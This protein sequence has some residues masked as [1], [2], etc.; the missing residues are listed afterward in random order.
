[1]PDTLRFSN[2]LEVVNQF[3]EVVNC[4]SCRKSCSELQFVGASC[5]HAFCWECIVSFKSAD[6][7]RKKLPLCPE[8][9]L[10]LDLNKISGATT[11]NNCYGYLE[12]LSDLLLQFDKAAGQ[13]DHNL[14]ATQ[15]ILTN[16]ENTGFKARTIEEF[17]CTQ[18]VEFLE[19]EGFDEGEKAC[20][21]PEYDLFGELHLNNIP[22]R[23]IKEPQ[24]STDK[25]SNAQDSREK[26]RRR[27]DSS[28]E[29]FLSKLPCGADLLFMSQVP[30]KNLAD[31][32]TPFVPRRSSIPAPRKYEHLG[33]AVDGLSLI[34]EDEEAL[35]ADD[36]AFSKKVTLTRKMSSASSEAP[37]IS[38]EGSKR[39]SM[40]PARSKRKSVAGHR[41]ENVIMSAI[42]NN[43]PD[44]LQKAIEA[45]EDV[46]ES[47]SRGFM[48]LYVATENNNFEAARM[49]I[50]AGAIINAACGPRC[51]TALH[52]A[53][54]CQNFDMIELLLQ[55]GASLKVKDIGGDTTFE[56][57]QYCRATRDLCQKYIEKPRPLQPIIMPPRAKTFQV[58]LIDPSLATRWAKKKL[59][60]NV[61]IVTRDDFSYTHLALEVDDAGL[62]VLDGTNM[63]TVLKAMMKSINIVSLSWLE[64]CLEGQVQAVERPYEISQIRVLSGGPIV[65]KS[66]EKWRKCIER[67][68]AKLFSGCKFYFLRPR[69]EMLE[70]TQLVELVR[71]G[72]GEVVIRD[73]Y[74]EQQCQWPFHNRLL[75][76]NFV[77]YS[78]RHAVPEKYRNSARYSLV[79]EQWLLETILTFTMGN[80][81]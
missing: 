36:D 68:E 1:M 23:E 71:E 33:R 53:A 31:D 54:R 63:F 18:P 56:S 25:K 27:L 11:L 46:N 28:D 55:K 67:R 43:R 38:S 81:Y 2:T 32:I 49:L 16:M 57:L 50:D 34:H 37:D 69:Y 42:L 41:G 73:S 44:L 12:E 51:R 6:K 72:G 58:H 66:I 9:Y 26:K 62:F 74:V 59:P 52:E 48:P 80:P 30:A 3:K 60:N 5:K 76:P 21:S 64:E 14:P 24:S 15:S 39:R 19:L 10:Q 40:S 22:L 20:G 13:D 77:V 75:S 45:G 70:R 61:Q 4:I 7:K 65:T 17:L 79:C 78:I 29:N 35:I 8:C 47:N